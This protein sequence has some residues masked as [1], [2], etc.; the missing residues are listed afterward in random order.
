MYGKSLA[1]KNNTEQSIG[2]EALKIES[3][4]ISFGLLI[5]L[6]TPKTSHSISQ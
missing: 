4:N 1:Q 6:F 3:H 2:E 5:N